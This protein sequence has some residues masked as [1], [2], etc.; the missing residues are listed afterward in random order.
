MMFF[1]YSKCWVEFI[2][3]SPVPSVRYIGTT[4][5]VKVKNMLKCNTG[6]ELLIEDNF[7]LGQKM[8]AFFVCWYWL[9]R[10]DVTKL[11][12]QKHHRGRKLSL[13]YKFCMFAGHHVMATESDGAV[14]L[15]VD[16]IVP[17]LHLVL[18]LIAY[19]PNV[20]NIYLEIYQHPKDHNYNI[21]QTWNVICLACYM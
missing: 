13:D 6:S 3:L 8:F 15:L 10:R 7:I 4:C 19:S 12:D 5:N 2:L 17:Q 11:H 9:L 1:I 16:K 14:A 21:S 20:H 18:C